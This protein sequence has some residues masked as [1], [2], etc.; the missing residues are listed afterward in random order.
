MTVAT[1]ISR[2]AATMIPTL[3]VA[4]LGVTAQ[5]AHAQG[6]DAELL[7]RA[8]VLLAQ[9]KADDAYRLLVSRE[10]DL[11]GTP[12]YDY[13]FGVAALDSG[14]RNDA[15]LGLERVLARE[16]D[17]A[18]ARMEFARALFELGRL[19]DSRIQ[20]AHL[21]G[22]LPPPATRAVIERYLA[23]ID[24]G[25]TVQGS[26]FTPSFTVGAGYD[27]NANGATADSQFLGFTLN[28]R[29][30]E[31]KSSFMQLG[32]ALGHSV[33]LGARSGLNSSLRV[34]YRANP[35]ASFVDQLTAALAS[36]Y[37]L[38]T[39]EWR[40][41]VGLSGFAG[42]LDGE[43]HERGANAELGLAR[44]IA[45][46]LELS[47]SLRGGP[48]RYE[49]PALEIMDVE[50]YLG[51]LSLQRLNI[52][53]RAGRAGLTL[54]AGRD[55][56]RSATS[57]YGSDRRGARAFGSVLLRPQSALYGELSWITADFDSGSGFFG[58][59]RKDT[60]GTAVLGLDLQNFPRAGWS[61]GP[62]LRYT[63]NDSNV[64]LYQYERIEAAVFVRHVFR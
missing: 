17:F 64:S 29:N 15:A 62:Q 39:G 46:D 48:L 60:Q 41:T 50:R 23:A 16:P 52:G 26:R 22:Q 51:G 19:G 34:D 45:G 13:L 8:Q 3:L 27:S 10:L 21:L 14:R 11:A 18:G 44:R 49:S 6:A 58:S 32:A 30:V 47:A 54:L 56:P 33:G 35:D 31:Q 1:Q 57:P 36:T 61:I 5:R 53:E 55:D 9:R 7:E 43:S 4:C 37:V 63:Q 28:P 20:F 24:N 25:A 59:R 2:F 42:W 38:K 40:T 12:R